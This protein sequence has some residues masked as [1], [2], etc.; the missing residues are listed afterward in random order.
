MARGS[1]IAPVISSMPGPADLVLLQAAHLPQRLV[2]GVDDVH[3]ARVE[4]LDEAERFLRHQRV[5]LLDTTRLV[6]PDIGLHKKMQGFS[7]VLSLIMMI[8][9]PS[10]MVLI[11]V[12]SQ[13]AMSFA[14]SLWVLFFFLGLMVLNSVLTLV[15]S[16]FD[17]SLM[18]FLSVLSL[19]VLI[20]ALGLMV[21]IFVLSKM[22]C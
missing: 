21:L 18:L 17:L 6:P 15:V 12:L 13:M 10:L 4:R 5:V 2:V 7:F 16:I 8:F 11:F 22:V 20:L 9:A 1:R 3:D 19:M 14:L